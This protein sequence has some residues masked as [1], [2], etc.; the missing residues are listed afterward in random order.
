MLLKNAPGAATQL[1]DHD[2]QMLELMFCS[3]PKAV[4][5]DT[6]TK[7]VQ[8]WYFSPNTNLIDVQISR[9]RKKLR[10]YPLLNIVTVRGYGYA[11]DEHASQIPE[12]D[13]Y[14]GDPEEYDS[15]T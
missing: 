4:S 7:E 12:I 13:S 9:L 1:T 6:F 11:L 5:R 14:L 10:K 2:I 3:Y 15:K 8:K